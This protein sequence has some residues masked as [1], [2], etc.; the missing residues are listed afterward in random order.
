MMC[1]FSLKY[2]IYPIHFFGPFLYS[3]RYP[4]RRIIKLRRWDMN[5][6][7][8]DTRMARQVI[9]FQKATFDNT[10]NAI[11]LLQDQTENAFYA[12][13]KASMWPVPEE[14]KKALNEWV[15]T[16]K[17]EREELKKVMDDG[18]DR[19]EN[20]FTREKAKTE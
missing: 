2:R 7:M 17:K 18:F 3:F 20:L 5:M 10:F 12:L 11:S 8:T 14:T 6:N 9:D 13:L 16:F 1:S 15:Q 19:V 4:R